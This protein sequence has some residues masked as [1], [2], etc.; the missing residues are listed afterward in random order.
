M[1]AP[2]PRSRLLLVLVA[3]RLELEPLLREE[4][5]PALATDDAP[6]TRALA[7]D[8]ADAVPGA[9]GMARRVAANRPSRHNVR[10]SCVWRARSTS[11]GSEGEG[12]QVSISDEY[13]SPFSTM[14]CWRA[15]AEE[16]D[17]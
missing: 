15:T 12:I 14:R 13:K 8:C 1:V 5:P 10:R 6:S 3:P 16:T 4:E 9:D 17:E 11:E 2:A 7:P